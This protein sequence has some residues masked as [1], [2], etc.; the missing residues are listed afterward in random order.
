MTSPTVIA[1]KIGICYKDKE[2][3]KEQLNR[4]LF[5]I[6]PDLIEDKS[7]RRVT[8][9]DGSYIVVF[10]CTDSA[11]GRKLDN[12]Y[13]QRGVDPEF[14]NTVLRPCILTTPRI[15]MEHIDDET[16]TMYFRGV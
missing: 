15:Q 9:K 1:K 13:I 12:I 14:I 6:D 11:R 2:W 8:F 5:L 16:G 7:D 4:C 10:P 3:G